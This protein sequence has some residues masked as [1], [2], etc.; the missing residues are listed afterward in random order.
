M[1][2]STRAVAHGLFLAC[3]AIILF[4]SKMM[5]ELLYKQKLM[6]QSIFGAIFTWATS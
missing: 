1:E 3:H 2:S 5:D 6:F 4:I